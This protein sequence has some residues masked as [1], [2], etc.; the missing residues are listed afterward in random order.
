MGTLVDIGGW[1]V[2]HDY[3]SSR[4]AVTNGEY[5]LGVK[6]FG[7]AGNK[8]AWIVQAP[9]SGEITRLGIQ[10]IVITTSQSIDVRVEPVGTDGNPTGSLY[11]AGSSGAIASVTNSDPVFATLSVPCFITA[12][13][14]FAVVVSWTGTVGDFEIEWDG[15]SVNVGFPYLREYTGGAWTK[16]EGTCCVFVEYSGGDRVSCNTTHGFM[17]D[18]VGNDLAVGS[19]DEGGVKFL[20]PFTCRVIGI[21]MTSIIEG[22]TGP[23]DLNIITDMEITLYDA[24]SVVLANGRSYGATYNPV[25]RGQLIFFFDSS[26][27][28]AVVLIPNTLYRLTVRLYSHAETDPGI[29]MSGVTTFNTGT[30]L[31]MDFS[32]FQR[33]WIWTHRA[34]GGSWTDR[35]W[36]RACFYPVIDQL[37]L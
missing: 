18:G 5:P 19:V 9:K 28:P 20:V 10:V 33:D 27:S 32:T 21:A 26:P 22:I 35:A 31:G 1:M 12:G 4:D 13:A 37:G 11:A 15:R 34:N 7:S 16:I 14:V 24:N 30:G 23:S 2:L 17:S 3:A 25:A 36:S 8:L 6:R 29:S